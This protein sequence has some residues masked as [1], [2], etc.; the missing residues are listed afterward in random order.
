M[1]PETEALL[2]IPDS[3]ITRHREL[4]RFNATATILRLT[5]SVTKGGAQE[6]RT[7]AGTVR[8]RVIETDIERGQESEEAGQ[9]VATAEIKLALPWDTVLEATDRLQLAD[10]K[11]VD[12][13]QIQDADPDR[14]AVYVDAIHKRRPS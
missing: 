11:M 5:I 14:A 4:Q 13:V 9:L 7:S 1:Y 6:S 8:Y 10:G 12:L 2:L 3:R